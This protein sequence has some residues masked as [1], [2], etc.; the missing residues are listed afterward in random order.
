VNANLTKK[1]AVSNADI[2]S[3]FAVSLVLAS[4]ILP[5]G[6]I[7]DDPPKKDSGCPRSGSGGPVASK[8]EPLGGCAVSII[9]HK[10]DLT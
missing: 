1:S 7:R 10:K 2:R 4:L 9:L 6:I 8:V 5:I 3:L